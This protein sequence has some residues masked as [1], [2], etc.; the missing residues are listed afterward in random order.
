MKSQ[1]ALL[2]IVFVLSL[3]WQARADLSDYKSKGLKKLEAHEADLKRERKYMKKAIEKKRAEAK[4]KS[5][6]KLAVEPRGESLATRILM[7]TPGEPG[8]VAAERVL[9]EA[10]YDGKGKR[11][12]ERLVI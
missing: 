2:L 8:R 7:E 10:G 4:K 12:A 11:L 3:C 1:V 9:E 5:G 6:R